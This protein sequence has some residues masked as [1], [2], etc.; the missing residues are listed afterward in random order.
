ML[1]GREREHPTRPANQAYI[2]IVLLFLTISHSL[3]NKKKL[4]FGKSHSPSDLSVVC[5]SIQIG[6]LEH[7]EN[8]FVVV[9]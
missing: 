7:V 6:I 4:H 8:A 9:R 1:R 5:P 3:F 2:T